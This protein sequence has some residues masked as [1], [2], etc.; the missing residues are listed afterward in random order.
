M[1]QSLA[2]GFSTDVKAVYFLEEGFQ[3]LAFL[4][5]SMEDGDCPFPPS[6]CSTP[7]ADARSLLNRP[8]LLH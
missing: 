8:T 1:L 3:F 5:I 2:S 4:V 7:K 6:H